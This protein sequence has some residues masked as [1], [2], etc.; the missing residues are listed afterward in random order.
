MFI[1]DVQSSRLVELQI[2]DGDNIPLEASEVILTPAANDYKE[3][4]NKPTLDGEEII[5]NIHEKDPTV[6][7][8]AKEVARPTYNY[9][10]VGAVGEKQLKEIPISTLNDMWNSL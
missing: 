1:R 4:K 6:P 2:E 3:L 10:D 5:G 9:V 8:W 7:A